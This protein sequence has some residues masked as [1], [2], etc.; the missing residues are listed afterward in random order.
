MDKKIF[1]SL[2]QIRKHAAVKRAFSSYAVS[3]CES[4]IAN[5]ELIDV[6]CNEYGITSEELL[7]ILTKEDVANLSF[8]DELMSYTSAFKNVNN[9]SDLPNTENNFHTK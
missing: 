5:P 8:L 3:V 1:E 7:T 4:L 2:K 6:T 9:S